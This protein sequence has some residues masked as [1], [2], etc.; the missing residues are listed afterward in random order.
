MSEH[1][2]D[3]RRELHKRKIQRK[4]EEEIKEAMKLEMMGSPVKGKMSSR[5]AVRVTTDHNGKLLPIRP[6]K[7]YPT[8]TRKM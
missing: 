2:D 8:E 7:L 3:L 5:K 6:A 1:L 4:V